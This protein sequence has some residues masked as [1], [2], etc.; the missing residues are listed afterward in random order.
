MKMYNFCKKTTV[1]T[2]VTAVFMI[3]AAFQPI[4][5]E[6]E[7]AKTGSDAAK[8]V[9]FVIDDFGNNM[10][11]T[12]EMLSLPIPLTVAVMPFL[13]TTKR[14]AELAHE[15]GHDVI[16][17][18]PMEPLRGKKSWLGPGAITTDMSDQEIR[19]RVEAAIDEVPHAIGMNNHM[20]S[21]ATVDERVMRVVLQ[22]CKE[23]GLFFLDSHTN[24]RTIVPRL[25]KE[26][27]IPFAENQIFLDDILTT[28]H[29]LKQVR[30]VEQYMQTHERCIVIGHVGVAGKKTASALKQ[31][32]PKLKSEMDI[33]RVS[34]FVSVHNTAK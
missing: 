31:A 22:V 7:P 4:L 28:D 34:Q 26:I 9:A 14:D 6:A 12:E 30:K 29:I 18:M 2:L 23:R 24:Y 21:K 10:P 11:G 13:Q 17:H 3:A 1:F 8:R 16:V 33:V 27:G 32:I 5:A 15:R 19:K 25:A 20:G